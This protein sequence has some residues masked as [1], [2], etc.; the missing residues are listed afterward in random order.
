MRDWAERTGGKPFFGSNDL[1]SAA[2]Q[3][4]EAGSNYYTLTYVPSKAPVG[5]LPERHI[6]VEVARKDVTL[7]YRDKYPVDNPHAQNEASHP[8]LPS[9]PSN[10][11]AGTAPVLS[12]AMR[13]AMIHGAPQPTEIVFLAS[14]R[15]STVDPEPAVAPGNKV[16]PKVKGPFRRYTVRYNASAANLDCPA[17]LDGVHHCALEFAA[18]VYDSDGTLVNSQTN[19]VN[20]ALAAPSYKAAQDSGVQYRQQISVPVSG[21]FSLRVGILD[22]NSDRVGAIGFPLAEAA[23]LTPVSATQP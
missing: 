7:F 20:A 13:V 2:Q 18:L 15:P 5:I 10:A 6:K 4:V 1:A 16:E 14:A 22:L 11:P 3:A 8:L 9:A 17:T 23:K 21:E 19:A 12:N